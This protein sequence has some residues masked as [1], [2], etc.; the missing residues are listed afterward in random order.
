M[1]K[2]YILQHEYEV[3]EGDYIYDEAK[4]LGVFSNWQKAEEALKEYKKL[5]GFR[6][7]PNGF[8]ID[9]YELNKRHWVEGFVGF[10]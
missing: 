3:Y 10:E 6:N 5:P 2:V 7:H 1:Q 8:S 9:E 4:D